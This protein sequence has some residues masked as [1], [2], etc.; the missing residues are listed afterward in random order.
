MA[1]GMSNLKQDLL[2]P[3]AYAVRPRHIE[4]VETHISWVFLLDGEVYK[5]KKPVDFGFLDFGTIEQRRAACDAEV[6]YNA[7][8]AP[9]V[10]LGVVPIRRGED[11]RCVLHGDGPIVDWAVHMV[12][13]ADEWRADQRLA[14][15]TLTTEDLDAVAE[16]LAAFHASARHD[17]A[18]ASLGSPQAIAVNVRENFLQTRDDIAGYL[19]PAEADEVEAWQLGIL[20]DQAALFGER[21]SRG[22]VRDGH[23]DLRLEHLY[24]G[25]AGEVTIIDCIEFNERFRVGDVCADV[26]FL[27]MD[28]AWHG[29]VDLAERLLASY[30]RH[31]DDYDLYALVDFYQSYRAWVRGKVASMLT[32][33]QGAPEA[34]RARAERDARRYFVLALAAD[35]KP[36]LAP[37]VIAVGG[38]IASGKSTLADRL[39][40][41]LSAPVIDSDRTRKGMLG[42]APTRAV[43]EP[44]WS[45]AYDPAFTD[46]VYNEVLRRARVVLAS[47]RPVIL[48]ASFRS[49][50]M[51]RQ[52]RELAASHG[53]P[54]HFVECAAAREVCRERLRQRARSAHVSDGRLDIF[55]DFAQHFQPVTELAAPE[56]VVVDTARP[57]DESVRRVAERVGTWPR[58]LVA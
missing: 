34:L 18:T 44:A 5:V 22:R 49:A 50:A 36:L 28:L 29:R 23:G 21:A 30:A 7:R 27:S 47:G 15:G 4:L 17:A 33:D 57:L 12:R 41:A 45:G 32:R 6:R 9:Q 42:V 58:G 19:R 13:L 55:D 39:G 3:G 20:R 1:R 2:E 46:D 56:H 26:A 11:G 43:S 8:L 53:V 51:R 31:A 14:R 38:L 48:D 40:A 35:K 25:P 10:Y 24:F 54:F 16:R 37:R 52:A